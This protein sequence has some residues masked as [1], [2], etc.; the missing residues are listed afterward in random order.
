MHFNGLITSSACLHKIFYTITYIPRTFQLA[1][2]YN[3]LEHSHPQIA[4]LLT[5]SQWLLM[6]QIDSSSMKQIDSMLPCVC[7]VIDHRRHQSVARTSVMHPSNSWCEKTLFLPK[8]GVICDL[9]L[10]RRTATRNLLFLLFT[11]WRCKEIVWLK[12][13]DFASYVVAYN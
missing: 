13:P 11:H 4:S 3:L 9:L 1:T 2:I 10:N 8:F 6:K 5:F 7:L 12:L